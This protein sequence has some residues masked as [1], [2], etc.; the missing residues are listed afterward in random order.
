MDAAAPALTIR[1]ALQSPLRTSWDGALWIGEVWV[2]AVDSA[3][4]KSR[5][6]GLPVRC[7]LQDADGYSRARLLVRT[8]G[9]PLGF[10]EIGVSDCDVDFSELKRRVEGLRATSSID[11]VPVGSGRMASEQAAARNSRPVHSRPGRDAKNG[12]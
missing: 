5:S 11:P 1:P 7:R 12:P 4:R 3:D 10:V 8:D 6:A 2:D 9:R